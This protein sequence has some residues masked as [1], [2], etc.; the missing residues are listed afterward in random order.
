MLIWFHSQWKCVVHLKAPVCY[1]A[2]IYR[3]DVQVLFTWNV[4]KMTVS[5]KDI[6]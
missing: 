2:S 3:Q 4:T 6:K 5:H 1:E